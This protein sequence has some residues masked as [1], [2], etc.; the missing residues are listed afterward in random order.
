MIFIKKVQ[1]PDDFGRLWPELPD[2][3]HAQNKKYIKIKK[4]SKCQDQRQRS[5]R[6]LVGGQ[7]VRTT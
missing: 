5:A 6:R 1:D 3:R 2:A 4:I 7:E